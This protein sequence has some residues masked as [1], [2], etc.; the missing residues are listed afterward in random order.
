MIEIITGF[1]SWQGKLI[2]PGSGPVELPAFVERSLV[3]RGV[4]VYVQTP[5]ANPQ[6]QRCE[7]CGGEPCANPSD[8]QDRAEGAVASDGCR[9]RDGEPVTCGRDASAARKSVPYGGSK[10]A[11]GGGTPGEAC[12]SSAL[13]APSP[14]WEGFAEE[15]CIDV[16]DGHMTVESLMRLT[17]AALVRLAGELGLEAGRRDT[18]AELAALIA[19][20]EVEAP[21]YMPA[22]SRRY[23]AQDSEQPPALGAELPQ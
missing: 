22:D 16:V 9:G 6:E 19:Q 17:R 21:E 18:K 11:D 3:E 8:G 2:N 4:A 13:R 20:V 10:A 23:G 7:T 15:D 12:P 5:L 14:E 1:T